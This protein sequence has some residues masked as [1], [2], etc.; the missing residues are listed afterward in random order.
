MASH[1]NFQSKSAKHTR[2]R[3]NRNEPQFVGHVKGR[4]ETEDDNFTKNIH[5]YKDFVVWGRFYPDLFFDLITPE[6]GG[7]RL[8]LDQRV[9]LRAMSR[10]LS[11]YGVF[12]RGYGKTYLE[13]LGM[14][15]A[16][17]FFPDID[18]SMTAQTR[19][20]AAKLVDEKHREIMKH[21]PLLKEEVQT[22]RS[23]KD[24]VEVVFTS[25]GR[26]DV[27]ANQQS[28][29]GARRKR[30]NV[31]EAA[32]INNDLFQ[33]V[34]EPIVNI[35]RRTIGKNSAVNPEE[36][37][38]QINFFTTSWFRGTSEYDRNIALYKDM[39]NLKGVFLIGSDWQLAHSFGRGETKSQILSKKEKLSPTFFA[40]NYE[41]RWVGASSSA[42][43]DI[44]KVMD[45]RVMTKPEY[46]TDG[47][48]EYILAMDVA[49]SDDTS[50]NQ[51]SIAV[52][53]L[54]RTKNGRIKH[55]RLVNIINLPNGLNFESQ[56]IELKKIKKVFNASKVVI[57]G[58]GLG[59]A[60]IDEVLKETFDPKTG[61]SLGCWSTINTDRV[62]E[63]SDAEKIVYDLHSQG[64]NSDIII[65]FID[66]VEAQ[67][68]LLLEKVDNANYDI[69]DDD[70]LKRIAP[71]MQTDILIEEIANLKLKE[72]NSG[73]YTVEQVVRKIDKDRYS[74]VAY[75]LW[76]IKNFEDE[77][78]SG[79]E[80]EF[81]F[82]FN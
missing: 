82:F 23:S 17:I 54:D 57:D 65:N 30:L 59:T 37:N 64:I 46:K 13:I 61:D 19:E 53:K 58:N 60:I 11:T 28:T 55:I 79:E 34:L 18:I 69:N 72:L 16:A 66:M 8:D 40:L 44:K 14:Y 70:D 80:Y 47:R 71:F 32:Q 33:D 43:V 45:L 75:G 4:S 39:I 7:I 78:H 22:Y 12:P 3:H 10:F 21:F 73:K 15:H 77:S 41:S 81:G 9:F 6:V 1:G 35:P 2:N 24:S 51:S 56:A 38:G 67:K 5:K 48:S 36:M 25:G 49:R 50:N 26:I 76:F 31:E 29:K 42:L 27:L 63:S 74:A 68:L 62:P 20:N 52:L